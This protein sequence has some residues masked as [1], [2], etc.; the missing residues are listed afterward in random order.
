MLFGTWNCYHQ[1]FAAPEKLLL[2]KTP[3]KWLDIV[4]EGRRKEMLLIQPRQRSRA[5]FDHDHA[6]SHPASWQSDAKETSVNAQQNLVVVAPSVASTMHESHMF[7]KTNVATLSLEELQQLSTLVTDRI[8][9]KKRYNNTPLRRIIACQTANNASQIP[10]RSEEDTFSQTDTLMSP[11]AL[12]AFRESPE[13]IQAQYNSTPPPRILS[14]QVSTEQRK[15]VPYGASAPAR[16]EPEPLEVRRARYNNTPL[17][18]VLSR[19]TSAEKSDKMTENKRSQTTLATPRVST[20]SHVPTPVPRSNTPLRRILSRQASVQTTTGKVHDRVLE[21][22]DSVIDPDSPI[23]S[24]KLDSQPSATVDLNSEARIRAYEEI[25][26]RKSTSS[27]NPN[28]HLN[29]E[30]RIRVYEEAVWAKQVP[31]SHSDKKTQ[32]TTITVT[33]VSEDAKKPKR[34]VVDS[35]GSPLRRILQRQTSSDWRAPARVA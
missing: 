33:E 4:K 11:E 8:Q 23:R 17:R 35:K 18:R 25:L 31:N 24:R 12:E 10:V 7:S 19:Q 14:R 32:G 3:G 5:T 22:A 34:I 6:T 21:R 1:T 15:D 27:E 20:Q 28:V 30:S 26:W 16:Y 9:I 2:K 29:S 13:T